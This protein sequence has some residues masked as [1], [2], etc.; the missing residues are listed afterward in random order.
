MPT[1]PILI[2]VTR[3]ILRLLKGKRATGVDRVGLAYIQHYAER[4]L[5][6][7]SWR[8][9]VVVLSRDLSQ[10]VFWRLLSE[11]V[12]RKAQVFWFGCLLRLPFYIRVNQD[13]QDAFLLNTGHKGLESDAYGQTLKRMGVRPVYFIHD[14]IPLTHAEYCR[15]REYDKHAVR[16]CHALTDS[17]GLI[18]NSEYTKQELVAFAQRHKLAVPPIQTAWL[19][20]GLSDSANDK[21]SKSDVEF[22][23]SNQA[24]FVVLGTIEA[25]KNHLLL[26]HVWRD[27]VER[28]GEDNVPRLVIVGQRGWE[29]EQ[30]IDLLERSDALRSVVVEMNHVT[31]AQLRSI[32]V[33]ARALLF[34]SFVEGFGMPLVEALIQGIP[35]IAS[36]IPVFR[37]I[38]QGV[39]DWISPL[40]GLGW[41]EAILDYAQVDS[42]KRIAQMSRLQHYQ[43][44]GW[45]KH[46]Q[47]VDAFLAHLSSLSSV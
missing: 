18:A 11:S 43:A 32:L 15:P 25:R 40:D 12:D 20:S 14:L 41:S 44:F 26:L 10:Q 21:V 42:A 1:Q 45:P 37:E 27:L 5:A 31:D 17:V 4:A 3:L 39:P 16:M 24:Y 19:A 33:K 30:V 6:V 7:L 36:D 35:V 9:R 28:L 23:F 47:M 34:P 8:G 13:Y 29:C 22:P 38:G 2:D 46:F